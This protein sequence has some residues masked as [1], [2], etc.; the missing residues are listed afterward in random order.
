MSVYQTASRSAQP[1]APRRGRVSNGS[2]RTRPEVAP[3]APALAVRVVPAAEES[4]GGPQIRVLVTLPGGTEVDVTRTMVAAVAHAL[5]QARGEDHLTNW[6]DAENIVN[7]ALSAPAPARPSRI[8]RPT[9]RPRMVEEDGP[10]PDP[11]APSPR[12]RRS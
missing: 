3:A 10:L 5:W 6:F 4:A 2:I 7:L 8:V 12:G 1:A 11:L 9:P